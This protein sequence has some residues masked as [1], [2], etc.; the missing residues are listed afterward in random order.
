MSRASRGR[1]AGRALLLGGSL[2]TVV[3]AP[4]SWIVVDLPEETVRVSG[5]AALSQ[6][7]PALNGVVTALLGAAV[8]LLAL[9]DRPA[10]LGAASALGLVIA[11]VGGVYLVD[12]E[13]AY[14]GGSDA[15]LAATVT[16]VAVGVPLTVVAG[17]AVLVGGV[18][19]VADRPDSAGS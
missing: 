17:L 10:G 8:A 18:V 14:G 6:V 15:A 16:T 19:L 3:A 4:L 5:L 13:L 9:A 11:A 1:L 7:H 2:L 12:L